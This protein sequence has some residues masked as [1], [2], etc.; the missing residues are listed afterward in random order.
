MALYDP[1]DFNQI[2]P[3]GDSITNAGYNALGIDA[4]NLIISSGAENSSEK[5]LISNSRR[6]SMI[7]CSST[8]SNDVVQMYNCYNLH[9]IGNWGVPHIWYIYQ[10]MQNDTSWGFQNYDYIDARLH[11]K[12]H[13][14]YVFCEFLRCTGDI[15]AYNLSDIRLKDDVSIMKN[16]LK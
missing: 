6:C 15:K 2:S 1:P 9:I 5:T 13:R 4:S 12:D 8:Q 11:S 7:G 10:I 3:P 16:C 14:V